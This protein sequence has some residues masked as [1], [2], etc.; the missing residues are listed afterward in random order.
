[1]TS[2][3][4]AATAAICASAGGQMAKFPARQSTARRRSSGSSS[5]PSRQPVIAKYFEKLSP[6]WLPRR[7]PAQLVAGAPRR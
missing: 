5:Q 6:R 2:G 4:N 7:L 3:V 1:M